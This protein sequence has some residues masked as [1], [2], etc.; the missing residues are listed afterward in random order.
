MRN[1]DDSLVDRGRHRKG[2]KGQQIE[3]DLGKYSLGLGI[4]T[5]NFL[6]W[7]PHTDTALLF[8]VNPPG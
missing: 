4:Y 1:S 2:I 7:A 8:L 6:H 5:Q 3:M